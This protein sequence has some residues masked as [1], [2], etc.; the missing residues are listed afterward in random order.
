MPVW[1]GH[2]LR[3]AQGRPCPPPLILILNLRAGKRQKRRTGPALSGDGRSARP[4]SLVLLRKWRPA[5]RRPPNEEPALSLPKG[6]LHFLLI[7]NHPLRF[8][9]KHPPIKERTHTTTASTIPAQK[10]GLSCGASTK[11]CC[12]ICTK[13]RVTS[14]TAIRL[15]IR[16]IR[17]VV[18]SLRPRVSHRYAP[19]QRNVRVG[20]TLLSA[21]IDLG[22]PSAFHKRLMELMGGPISTDSRQPGFGMVRELD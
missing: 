18:V 20:R 17:I 14:S 5:A 6:P 19:A 3:Q 9:S 8:S 21:A 4:K 12:S 22:F 15:K 7:P 1:G 10:I 13:C 11:K 16:K 2:S